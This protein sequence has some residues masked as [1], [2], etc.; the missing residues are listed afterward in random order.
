MPVPLLQPG[1]YIE[2]VPSGVR[3]ITGVA[4]SIAVFVGWAQRGRTDRPVRLT[5]FADYERSHGG[6]DSRSLLGFA[7]RAFYHNGGSDAYVLRIADDDADTAECAIDDLS[8]EASS[9]GVWANAYSVRLTQRPDETSRFRL[10]V[11]ETAS[12]AVVESFANLSMTPT[13]PRFVKSVVNGRSAFI[14]NSTP[15]RR[16]RP[17]MRPLGLAAARRARTAPSSG[18][19]IPTSAR[20]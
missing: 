18:R 13:D 20:H 14:D 3:T 8:V 9:P 10:E 12:S 11:I 17:R 19:R 2:E 7:V 5:S 4:T 6:L 1:V 15:H 16:R